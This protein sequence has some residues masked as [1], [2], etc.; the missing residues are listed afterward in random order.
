MAE[1]IIELL[2]EL[3]DRK[4]M[5]FRAQCGLLEQFLNNRTFYERAKRYILWMITS[6]IDR[7]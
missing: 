6:L 7:S 3:N 1:K 4:P 5:M 2:N